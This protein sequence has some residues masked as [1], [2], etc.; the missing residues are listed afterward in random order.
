[1]ELAAE[2]ELLRIQKKD[3]MEKIR[4]KQATKPKYPGKL[5]GEPDIRL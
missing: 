5:D 1:M 4:A 3:V 2:D